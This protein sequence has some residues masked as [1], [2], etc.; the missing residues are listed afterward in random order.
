MI[1]GSG[2]DEP[3]RMDFALPYPSRR[4]PVM[5]RNAVASS[6]PLATQAGIRMLL[7]GGSAA[8]A[9]VAAAM[10]LTVVEPNCNGIGGDLFAIVWDGSRLHGLNASGRSPAALRPERFARRTAMPIRG[11]DSVTVPGGVS[12]WVELT[13]RFGRLGLERLVE[14]AAS[15]ARNGFPV[16]PIVSTDWAAKAAGYDGF[17]AFAAGFLPG[18]RA[19]RPGEIFRFPAQADT[20]ESIASSHGESFYRGELAD[21]IVT[22]SGRH[23]G[24]M[25]PQDLADHAPEWVETLSV[26]YHGSRL[27][28]LPP[29]GQGLA[30][31]LGL[32]I[33]RSHPSSDAPIDSADAVHLQIESMK[34]ALADVYRYCADPDYMD[35]DAGLLLDDGYLAARA[36]LIDMGSAGRPEYG[37]PRPGGTVYLT[38]ADESGMMVSLIQSNYYGFGS[39]IVIPGTGISMHDR[40]AGFTLAEGHP[41]AVAGGKRPF[42]TIIPGFLMRDGAPQMSF[43]VM[44]GAMQAQGHLQMVVRTVDHGQNP[45]AASDAPRWCVMGDRIGVEHGFPPD[46]LDELRRRGHAIAPF[47]AGDHAAF[48]GAQLIWRDDDTYIAGSD[49]RKDGQAAAY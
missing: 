16:S 39:G 12:G 10:A 26:E 23:G 41:N 22:D 34:L 33:L 20:L 30:A 4:S 25:T 24:V 36:A 32:G 37:S 42:H 43:G 1:A 19:P 21:A 45:Q 47:A 7:A 17:D 49:H 27:H 14:P 40:A 46:V 44:G 6:Q 3:G 28:E 8:D 38:A 11:W 13:D 9:A 35:V 31:L 15:Y 18:G 5:G 48:G 2:A 29:S